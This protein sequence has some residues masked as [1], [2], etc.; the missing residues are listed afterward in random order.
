MCGTLQLALTVPGRDELAEAGRGMDAMMRQ[1]STLVSSIRSE[2]ELVAMAGDELLVSAGALADRTDEQATNLA[3]T[4]GNVADLVGTVE[5]NARDARTASALTEQVREAADSGK[6]TVESAVQ[7]IQGLSQRADKMTDII[8]VIDGI[9][10]QTNI[11]ALN[12]AVEAARAG[13][14]GRGFAV[15]AAEVR[16]LAQRCTGA[17]S[18]VKRLIEGS[19]AEVGAGMRLIREAA[20][21]LAA[22][23]AGIREITGKAHLISAASSAQLDGLRDIDRS[24]QGLDTITHMCA[25][26]GPNSSSCAASTKLM[27]CLRR[28]TTS[29]SAPAPRRSFHENLAQ[30]RLQLVPL[31]I[32]QLPEGHP[33][34]H[35]SGLQCAAIQPHALRRERDML[36]ALVLGAALTRQQAARFQAVEQCREVRR[37]DRQSVRQGALIDARVSPHDRQHSE[38]GLPQVMLFHLLV[39]QRLDDEISAPNVVADE[40]EQR[41]LVRLHACIVVRGG[42]HQR[43][44]DRR[45]V[46]ESE[47][48]IAAI[49]A[50][51]PLLLSPT[52]PAFSDNLH[53]HIVM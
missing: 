26:S 45:L 23:D 42:Q 13:E 10:F 24:V 17:A 4:S 44:R 53:R 20:D 34:S 35:G 19:A 50:R 22:V 41:G 6:A 40:L 51:H 30:Q 5:I 29:D 16:S 1:L 18:E 32:V 52:P 43:H 37:G 2:S 12:A 49:I 47:H 28:E 8:G 9:A 46:E 15:V 25:R 14:A 11:L 3:Q 21:A 27:D 39:E 36:H 38:F 48:N 7:A 33:V 31:G